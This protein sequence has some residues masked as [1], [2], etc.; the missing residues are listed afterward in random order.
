MP[1]QVV[2]A[3]AGI[4][5]MKKNSSSAAQSHRTKRPFWFDLGRL[6]FPDLI[7]QPRVMHRRMITIAL[8][9]TAVLVG[10]TAGFF[11]RA[12]NPAELLQIQA[13]ELGR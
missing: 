3:L 4:I 8:I 11:H 10:A 7:N 2:P 12:S 6:I 9:L 13:R 1:I 5:V